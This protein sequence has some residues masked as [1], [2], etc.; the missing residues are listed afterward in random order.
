M[1]NSIFILLFAS[2]LN[3]SAQKLVKQWETPATLKV[4]ESVYLNDSILFVS[5]INGAPAEKNGEGYIAKV[6]L[7]G[8]TIQQKWITGLHAPKGMGVY[9]QH[10]YVTNIDEVA[11]IDIRSSK[12]VKRIK[13]PGSKFL[14]DIAVSTQGDVYISD[15]SN[16]CIYTI[17]HNGFKTFSKGP[18]LESVN[19]LWISDGD[20]FAGAAGLI[21]QFNINTKEHKPYIKNV[22][23]V[24]GLEKVN[25]Q[26]MINSDWSGTV[27][28]I[29]TKQKEPTILISFEDQKYNAA[30]VEF[31]TENQTLYIP[32]FFGNT[33]AAYKLEW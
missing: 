32:T 24:D 3:L 27:Q 19:G 5:C 20:L 2:A 9:G 18:H 23:G 16:Q 21:Y 15:Y 11:I 4:C 22:G 26:F 30:D 14:N 10:L 17:D 6:S 13:I 29:A 12:I 31:N 33:V 8:K 25:D 28:L 1:K 7:D